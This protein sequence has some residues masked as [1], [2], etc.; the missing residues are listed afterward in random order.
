MATLGKGFARSKTSVGG[1][2]ADSDSEDSD[3][4]EEGLQHTISLFE[5]TDDFDKL[6][7]DELAAKKK[8]SPRASKKSLTRCVVLSPPPPPL[9]L[10]TGR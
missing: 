10:L 3:V 5:N 6:F 8:A 7:D 2:G 4:G 9:L 1:D